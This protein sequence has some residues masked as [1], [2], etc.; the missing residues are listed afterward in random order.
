MT[1]IILVTMTVQST[2]SSLPFRYYF[3]F[4]YYVH[5]LGWRRR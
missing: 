2:S 5:Y 3:R 1:N 4:G